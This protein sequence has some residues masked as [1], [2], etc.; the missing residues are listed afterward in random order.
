M[1]IFFVF[2][3]HSSSINHCPRKQTWLLASST[4]ADNSILPWV[5]RE[6]NEWKI[7]KS[8]ANVDSEIVSL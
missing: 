1:G 7:L 8:L 2:Q 4:T 3:D 6:V 5:S